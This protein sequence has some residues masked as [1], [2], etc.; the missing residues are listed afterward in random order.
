MRYKNAY[1]E[2]MREFETAR[3]RAEELREARREELYKK[4]PRLSVIDKNLGELGLSVA[5]LALAGD[6]N[7]LQ[8]TREKIDALK[9]ERL[10][11][12]AKKGIS[13]NYLLPVYNCKNC[14]D[15]GY[16]SHSPGSPVT[17]CACLKQR[18]IEEYYSLS[19]MREVLRDENFDTFDIRLF[20]TEILESEGLSP[21][22]NIETNYRYAI[23]FVQNFD[24]EFQNLLL[25]GETGLGKT[26]LS[27]CIAKDLLDAGHT[28]LYLTV[29]RLCKIIE[30]AR[31]NRESLSAPDEML[32]AVDES[33][34]LVLDDLGAEVSTIVTSSA[35]FDIINQRLLMRKPTVIS[36]NLTPN[37]LA[38]QYS[39]RI[40]SRFLGNYQMLKFFGDDIRVKKKYG[41]IR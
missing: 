7:G 14:E 40:V 4:N 32:D 24:N 31:F 23:N 37:G 41:N 29:P 34:L 1:R 38:S 13:E 35:L 8:Q 36:T 20:S 11:L 22:T 12:L 9:Q 5:K 17:P 26:F 28:V 10:S 30:D 39:E 16:I 18:L 6:A 15:T 27:H 2:V 3:N 19:N 33:D 21:R 25:Y